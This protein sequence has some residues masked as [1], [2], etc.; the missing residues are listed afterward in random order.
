MTIPTKEMEHSPVKFVGRN[1]ILN[2]GMIDRVRPRAHPELSDVH[3][4]IMENTS[5]TE[6]DVLREAIEAR[7]KGLLDRD[8][9]D[10]EEIVYMQYVMH[11]LPRHVTHWATGHHSR[12][13]RNHLSLGYPP[14]YQ[15]DLSL[16][17]VNS[18]P[19]RQP[20]FQSKLIHRHPHPICR[21][22]LPKIY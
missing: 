19:N 8:F 15:L 11:R 6:A 14:L 17:Q 1:V 22:K 18:S 20:M 12:H 4:E 21:R 9:D 16:A 5:S 13:P 7:D 2:E 3:S 10:E